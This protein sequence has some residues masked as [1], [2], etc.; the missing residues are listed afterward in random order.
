MGYA[1]ISSTPAETKGSDIFIDNKL[2][3][4]KT[5]ATIPLVIGDYYIKLQK[6]GYLPYY[7][8]IIINE[9]GIT[10]VNAQMKI[11]PTVLIM[12]HKKKKIFWLTSAALTSGIGCFS[13]LK[14]N[15][16]YDDYQNAT[17]NTGEI[18]KK[19]RT[20]DIIAPIAFGMAGICFTGSII[21]ASKQ[22]KAKQKIQLYSSFT[23]DGGMLG[24][25]YTF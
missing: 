14:A 17:N 21:H 12:K 7:K 15:S 5:P 3:G 13:S 20:Y 19:I 23:M 10:L 18:R 16:L 22:G 24:L 11:D 1:Q 9:N 25:N 4:Q 2:T 8:K 6:D